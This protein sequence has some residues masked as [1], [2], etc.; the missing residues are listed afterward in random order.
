MDETRPA[1]ERS[2]RSSCARVLLVVS[3]ALA[4]TVAAIVVA[5]FVSEDFNDSV[6]LFMGGPEEVFQVFAFDNVGTVMDVESRYRSQRGAFG[7]IGDLVAVGELPARFNSPMRRYRI[8]VAVNQRSPS[9]A[10]CVIASPTRPSP[11]T[12]YLVVEQSG[13]VYCGTGIP[14][15]DPD[16]SAPPADYVHVGLLSDFRSR[17]ATPLVSPPMPR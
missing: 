4:C 5:G 12:P 1:H 15:I 11:A 14:V 7:T 16:A 3:G 9:V 13:D 6:T 2:R 17:R 8:S 10:F